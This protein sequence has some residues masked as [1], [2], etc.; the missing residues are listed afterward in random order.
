MCVD[1]YK[2]SIAT[3]PETHSNN[4]IKFYQCCF[5]ILNILHIKFCV[6]SRIANRYVAIQYSQT[7]TTIFFEGDNHLLKGFHQEVKKE[8]KNKFLLKFCALILK[9]QLPQNFCN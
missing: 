2:I 1:E 6:I 5:F 4:L 7:S 8:K 9:L 3:T